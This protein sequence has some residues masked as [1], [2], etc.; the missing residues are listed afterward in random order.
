MKNSEYQV[1]VD[2]INNQ[3]EECEKALSEYNACLRDFN[4]MTMENINTTIISC[5]KVQQFMDKFVQS[6]L[7]HIIGMANL[8]AAQTSHIMKLTKTLLKYRSDVKF[9]AC[10]NTIKVPERKENTIY[11]LS[12]GAKLVNKKGD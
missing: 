9:F 3:I 2:C 1:I 11:K 4:K 8:N 5:R 12:S 10:Q 6:D 7:Y